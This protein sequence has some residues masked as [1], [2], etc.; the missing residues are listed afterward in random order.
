MEK[1]IIIGAGIL[2]SSTAYHLAKNGA[3]VTV[4]DR[5]DSGQA[6]DAAAGIICPWLS[7]RR[8]KAWY[9]L[10]KS[11]AAHYPSLIEQLKKDGEIETGYRQVGAISLHSDELKLKK[12]EE[13][14]RARRQE[15]PEMGAIEWLTVEEC[16]SFFP[17]I[18]DQLQAIFVSGAARVDGRA[19]RNALQNAA[20]KHGA[21]FV[22]GSA[23]LASSSN[24]VTGVNVG[25]QFYPA[26][27]VILT[28]GAW[29][30]EI[31]KPLGINLKVSGQKAQIVHLQ[32]EN[33]KTNDWPVVIPPT[34]QY[35]VPFDHGRVVVG[36][37]HEDN[38]PFDHKVTIGGIH[39]I[40]TKALEIAPGLTEGAYVETRVGYRPFT[41]NFLPII[42]EFAQVKGLWIAN[43]LGASG[44]TIGPFLGNQLAKLVL[45]Q[46]VEIDLSLYRVEQAIE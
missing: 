2:G 32:I 7:Q 11:G 29:A 1:F 45:G 26:G 42:G 43:G 24:A 35:I 22:K 27:S 6:T 41:P 39:E 9:A 19:L 46:E 15:A 16:A 13:R 3:S 12:M 18:A 37:T 14:A 33:T 17:P 23:R 5:E 28:T 30:A 36:A 40:A 25:E 44:L 4:I 21:T 8:N 31:V 34:N 38:R 20:K 10:A